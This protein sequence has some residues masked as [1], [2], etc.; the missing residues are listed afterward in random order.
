VNGYRTEITNQI[1]SGETFFGNF[2]DAL[3]GMW[4]GLDIL[5]DPYSLSQKGRLRITMFQ[6]V[7]FVFRRAESFCRGIDLT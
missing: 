4:G 5:V 3:I 1:A 7:D 2:A 6:D